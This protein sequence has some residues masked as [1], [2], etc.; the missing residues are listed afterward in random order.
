[1]QVFGDGYSMVESWFAFG[2]GVRAGFGGRIFT[3]NS[4]LRRCVVYRTSSIEIATKYIPPQFTP[5]IGDI[6]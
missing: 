1:M 3:G 2:L 4:F 5:R 6:P